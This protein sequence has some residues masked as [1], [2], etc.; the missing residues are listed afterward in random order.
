MLGLAF[1]TGVSVAVANCLRLDATEPCQRARAESSD[2][3]LPANYVCKPVGA[4]LV[5]RARW[6]VVGEAFHL[7][8][9]SCVLHSERH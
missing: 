9:R 7:Q 5:G 1:D 3:D 6:R 4:L 2:D 8:R